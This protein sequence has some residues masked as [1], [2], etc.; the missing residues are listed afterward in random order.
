[1]SSSHHY[2]Y[3]NFACGKSRRLAYLMTL[4]LF[5]AQNMAVVDHV[6]S[7]VR[8]PPALRHVLVTGRPGEQPCMTQHH[9]S[10]LIPRAYLLCCVC[11]MVCL[12]NTVLCVYRAI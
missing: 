7:K 10:G 5:I 2:I 11:G 6:M 4:Y 3:A 9:T 1:M 8:V 12:S